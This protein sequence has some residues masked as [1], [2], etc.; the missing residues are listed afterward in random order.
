MEEREGS[1]KD[2]H[3][4]VLQLFRMSQEE[5]R[6]TRVRTKPCRWILQLPMTTVLPRRPGQLL[7]RA[8]VKTVTREM[9]N[10]HILL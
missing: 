5:G 10:F 2:V 6:K 9:I 7:R 1:K 4:I 8:A 3:Q